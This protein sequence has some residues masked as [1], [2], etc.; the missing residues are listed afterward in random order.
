MR[1]LL[2]VLQFPPDVNSNG[3]LM[4]QLG[5]EL[6][7]RGHQVSVITT[8][9]HYE[10]FR[11][12]NEYRRRLAERQPYRGMSVVRLYVHARGMKGHMLNRF[13]SYFSFALLATLAGLLDR[14]KYDVI[15][16]PNGGF[17]TGI[18]AAI[19]GSLR[20]VPVVLNVQ[21]LYPETPIKTGQIR[22]R[23]VIKLLQLLERWMYHRA[24]HVTVIT[25][26]F[27]DH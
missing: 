7:E 11:V 6:V 14:Q 10:H 12:W 2:L 26:S 19:V 25:P 17:L 3:V 23:W 8:F 5:E 22:S 1:I 27:V 15:L 24:V 20:R 21:D 4:A 18:A 16:C 9:P 13:V